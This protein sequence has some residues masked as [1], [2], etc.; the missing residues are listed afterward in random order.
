MPSSDRLIVGV[1]LRFRL[2]LK[3]G[4]ESKATEPNKEKAEMRG[5]V[6]KCLRRGYCWCS[7]WNVVLMICF[8]RI[9]IILYLKESLSDM[10][11]SKTTR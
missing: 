11:A 7:R 8:Y 5:L 2:R 4:E 10:K 1:F 3:R 6:T 9:V